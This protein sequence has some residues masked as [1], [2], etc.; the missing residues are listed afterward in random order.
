M[1]LL[2]EHMDDKPCPYI[3]GNV[4]QYCT[5]TPFT[6]TAE[7]REAIEDAV[8]SAMAQHEHERV[9]ALRGLLQRTKFTTE[10]E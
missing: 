2:A 9:A 4:T 1:T 5:L 6:L 7:E 10:G 8:Y 3:T